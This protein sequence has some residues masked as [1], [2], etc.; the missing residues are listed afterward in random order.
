MNFNEELQNGIEKLKTEGLYRELKT[1]SSAPGRDIVL[2][3]KKYVNFSSNNYLALAEHPEIKKAAIA[4]IEKFGTGGT[5]SRLV[6][7][8]LGIHT[9]LEE[10]LAAFKK[11]EKALVYPAGFQTNLGIISTLGGAG[12]CLIMDRLNHASLWDGAKLSGARIFVYRH[13]DAS[14]LEKVLKRA[15]GYKRKIIITDS[16]FSMDGDIAPLKEI[17]ALAK[18]YGAVT[19]I[20]EAH[21][22][23]VLGKEGRGLAELAE[24]EGEVDIIMGTLSKALGSQGGFVCGSRA[25]IEYL[26]N[27]SRAF[28]YTTAI[29]PSCAGAALAALDK[30]HSEPARRSNLLGLSADLRQKLNG[31]GINTAG[32]VTQIIPAVFGGLEQT[33][34]LSNKFFEAGIF[35]P[36][37]RPPTVPEGECRLRFSLTSEHT[38]DDLVNLI[39]CLKQ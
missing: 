12:D 28:I 26:V 3:G 29:A 15:K 13:A 22:T 33:L 2:S 35:A 6:G 34:K 36:A 39:N 19:M 38:E 25:L 23:G 10:K 16:V 21:S 9:E 14:S 31:L 27:K 4:A 8:T 17:V 30:V 32:S 20:D 1:S 37:I 24:V 18:Q 11:T 5:S 7:G